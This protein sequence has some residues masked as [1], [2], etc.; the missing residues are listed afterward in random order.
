MKISTVNF[1]SIL[2]TLEMDFQKGLWFVDF[3]PLQYIFTL[4]RK[5]MV[6]NDDQKILIKENME[7]IINKQ[8]KLRN[9]KVAKNL[10]VLTNA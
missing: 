7:I 10:K 3:G 9:L 2:N 4:A 6:S 5:M 8:F 1:K